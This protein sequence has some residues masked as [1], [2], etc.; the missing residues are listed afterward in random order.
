MHQSLENAA[1]AMHVGASS[2]CQRFKLLETD[3]GMTL[4]KKSKS[5]IELTGAGHTLVA[6]GTDI[7]N[8][9]E[10]L[11]HKLSRDAR[12][13]GQTLTV[14]GAHNP[15]ANHLQMHWLGRLY[16][17]QGFGSQTARYGHK[18]HD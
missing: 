2:V 12:V 4:Y 17:A 10:T 15:S 1:R 6:T 8:R 7:F 9:L 13:T 18:L 14:G 3:L 16:L 11:R 5:A